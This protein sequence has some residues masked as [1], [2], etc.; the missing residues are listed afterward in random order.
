MMNNSLQ[1]VNHNSQLQVWTKRVQDC[2][3]SELT[4]K[5]WCSENGIAV[6]T[7]YHWQ[8]KVFEAV[9]SHRS[10]H[11]EEIKIAVANDNCSTITVKCGEL[12]INIPNGTDI[13]LAKAVIA[14]VQ[15][16]C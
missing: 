12:E 15:A 3:S 13:N 2:R 11:F 7:Y 9:Q 8:K 16:S 5:Q 14:A 6:G 4:V 10:V 1:A